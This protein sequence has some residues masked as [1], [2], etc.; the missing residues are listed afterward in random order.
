M[1][2]YYTVL[3]EVTSSLQSIILAKLVQTKL[4][5]ISKSEPEQIL[6]YVSIT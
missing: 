6:V 3:V 1:Y 5:N 2:I 4:T